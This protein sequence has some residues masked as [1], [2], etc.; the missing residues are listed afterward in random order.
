MLDIRQSDAY[1]TLVLRTGLD[2]AVTREVEVKAV[3]IHADGQRH[4]L[5]VGQSIDIPGHGIV[6]YLEERM[7][8]TPLVELPDGVEVSGFWFVPTHA[9]NLAA[10][11]ATAEEYWRRVDAMTN[12]IDEMDGRLVLFPTVENGWLPVVE[13]MTAALL[14]VTAAE[15]VVMVT[16]KSKFGSL[17]VS[18]SVITDGAGEVRAR[19]VDDVAQWAEAATE[20]RCEV[21]GIPGWSGPLKPGSGGWIYTLSDEARKLSPGELRRRIH[22]PRPGCLRC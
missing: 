18:A 5:R 21:F 12:A 4:R 11:P 8:D 1:R 9:P 10:A 19:Y 2:P 15:D 6:R 16:T 13:A 20:G 22:P 17:R 7:D 3:D 14:L